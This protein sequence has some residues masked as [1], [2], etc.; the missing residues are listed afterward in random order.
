MVFQKQG[1]ETDNLE[2]EAWNIA[3]GYTQ[4]RILKPMLEL[5]R[6]EIIAQYG[7][8]DIDEGA[9][10]PQS[11]LN[12]RRIEALNRLITM[13]KQIIDNVDFAIKKSD[14]PKLKS[15]N[16]RLEQVKRTMPKIA[17]NEVDLVT[18]DSELIINEIL[19]NTC[20]E[21]LRKVKTEM[22]LPIN[23]AGLIFKVSDEV[24]IENMMNEII[25]GG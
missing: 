6:Y 21:I 10:L 1:G 18:H 14:R 4:L 9:E 2:S 22:N 24:D 5:D 20:L 8:Y 25:H 3:K 19:F 15:L 13:L 12:E 7:V 16:D 23:K 17:S 11:I